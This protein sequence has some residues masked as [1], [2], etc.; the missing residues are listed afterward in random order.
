MYLIFFSSSIR[1]SIHGDCPSADVS[2]RWLPYNS[3]Q[4]V[5]IS[6]VTP[7]PSQPITTLAREVSAIL[8]G[9]VDAELLIFLQVVM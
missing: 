8:F 3:A 2:T 7:Y 9:R 1:C 4:C 6:N 5:D